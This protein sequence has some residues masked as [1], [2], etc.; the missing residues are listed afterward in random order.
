[1]KKVLSI[2]AVSLISTAI[3]SSRISANTASFDMLAER[4][5]SASGYST[6]SISAS[7]KDNDKILQQ[8]LEDCTVKYYDSPN[9]GTGSDNGANTPGNDNIIDDDSISVPDK[10]LVPDED[11]NQN[12]SQNNGSSNQN[13]SINSL[14]GQ[15]LELVNKERSAVGLSPVTSSNNAL[16]NAAA[17]RAKEQSQLFS[18]TRPSGQNWTT[19]LSQYGVTY[20]TAGEN[21]AYGQKT[22]KEVMNAWMNSP[23][24][25]ANILNSNYKELGIGVYEKNGTYYWSQLF[26]G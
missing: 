3:L 24:H 1:M 5:A 10:P 23:G 6:A 13:T 4:F 25:R 22:A 2:T 19:V 11:S 16:N 26:I 9:C 7:I 17:L 18:H 14:A 21:V 8:L 15:I 20:R 12:N